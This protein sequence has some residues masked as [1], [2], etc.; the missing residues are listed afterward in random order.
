MSSLEK[1]TLPCT[2]VTLEKAETKFYVVSRNKLILMSVLSS[3][4]YLPYWHY[5]NWKAYRTATGEKVWPLI[6]AFLNIFFVYS[7]ATKIQRQLNSSGGQ[8]EWHPR[9]LAL[10]IMVVGIF[11][12]SMVYLPISVKAYL[13]ISL[14]LMVFSTLCLLRFQ[15]AINHLEGDPEGRQ[16]SRITLANG[17]WILVGCVVWFLL[18]YVNLLL[19]GYV[20]IH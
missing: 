10:V 16:N 2:E 12:N 15:A 18:I 6:R 5:R 14:F 1:T 20:S 9:L 3:G 19:S 13:P 4:F 8:Y 7:L 11:V 17:A